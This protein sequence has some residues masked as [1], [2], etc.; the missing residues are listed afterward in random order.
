M[1]KSFSVS[2]TLKTESNKESATITVMADSGPLA[3]LEIEGLALAVASVVEGK[4][5]SML[6]DGAKAKADAAKSAEQIK[7]LQDRIASMEAA[8]EASKP[9]PTATPVIMESHPVEDKPKH[10]RSR[11]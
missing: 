10:R 8:R 11:E 5:Q 6:P 7:K 2:I 4:V 9:V 3:G 1:I